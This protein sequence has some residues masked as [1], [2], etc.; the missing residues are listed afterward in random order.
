MRNFILFIFS[1]TDKDTTIFFFKKLVEQ[2]E[3]YNIPEGQISLSLISS[4]KYVE[5]REKRSFPMLFGTE[6]IRD[7]GPVFTGIS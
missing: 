1:V 2:T 4:A 3:S 7:N 6:L 5:N